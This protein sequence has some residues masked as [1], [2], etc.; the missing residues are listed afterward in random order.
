MSRRLVAHRRAERP[1]RGVAARRPDLCQHAGR[2]PPR[3]PAGGAIYVRTD[4]SE[5]PAAASTNGQQY[6]ITLEVWDE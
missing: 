2:Q 1:L 3:Y 5:V 4:G 6:A